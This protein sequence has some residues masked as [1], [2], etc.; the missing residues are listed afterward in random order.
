M[1][2]DCD[3]RGWAAA[4]N[5]ALECFR[6][7][8]TFG[9]RSVQSRLS[10]SAHAQPAPTIK[11]LESQALTRKKS[12]FLARAARVTTEEHARKAIAALVASDKR[13]AKATHNITA[14]RIRG[15]DQ[16]DAAGHFQHSND[17]GE[18]AA[19]GKVLTLLQMVD[20]WDVVVVVSRW[21]GG[22]KLGPERFRAICHVAKDALSAGGWT[23]QPVGRA[24]QADGVTGRP[25]RHTQRRKH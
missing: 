14:W 12:V 5:F 20:A 4:A 1:I 23:K 22:V 9:Y 15:C 24:G 17:D 8:D 10:S 25:P 18:H 16:A 13:V 6:I 19:G 11:W 7:R 2:D 3:G 21:Y